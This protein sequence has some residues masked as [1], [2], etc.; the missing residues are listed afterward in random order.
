M[1]L[2][3]QINDFQ[4][5]YETIEKKTYNTANLIDLKENLTE[6]QECYLSKTAKLWIQYLEYIDLLKLFIRAE[7]TGNWTLY[8]SAL[9][10]M[11]NLFAATG[12]LNYAKSARLHLQQMLELETTHPWVYIQTLQSTDI[13]Q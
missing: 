3:D 5:L 6:L 4:K 8:L 13:T 7:R 2:N 11:I 10:K 12:H 9:S 1:L